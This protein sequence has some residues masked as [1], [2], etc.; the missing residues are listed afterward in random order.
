MTDLHA[1]PQLASRGYFV[2]LKHTEV[3]EIPF[4]GLITRFSAKRGDAAQGVA[5]PGRRHRVRDERNP[6]PVVG[7]D[8]RIRRRGGV[9]VVASEWETLVDDLEA[10]SR[11]C[12][13]RST[14]LR[15]MHGTGRAPPTAGRCA[16]ASCTWR[17]PTTSAMA[18]VTGETLTRDGRREGVLTA[19]HAA[20]P[21]DDAG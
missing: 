13:R 2:R 20:R 19:G 17:R 15:S 5:L 14:M 8:R 3:G 16:I 11:S 12:R 1:D 6:G 9:H 21:L 4:D 10:E 7:R 18:G